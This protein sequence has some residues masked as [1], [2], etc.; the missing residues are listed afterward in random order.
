[1]YCSHQ[2]VSDTALTVNA[3]AELDQP[4]VDVLMRSLAEVMVFP[5]RPDMSN[6]RNAVSVPF[7]SAESVVEVP[8]ATDEALARLVVVSATG[9]SVAELLVVVVG[10]GEAG[11]AMVALPAKNEPP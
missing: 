6:L 5:A 2:P 3:L 10:A 9:F 11:N 4:C 7:R 8:P 1:M